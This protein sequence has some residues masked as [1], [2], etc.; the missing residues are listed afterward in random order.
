MK[1][2]KLFVLAIFLLTMNL[3]FSND[4]GK[5]DNKGFI[6]DWLIRGPYPNYQTPEYELSG[7]KGYV[8]DFLTGIGGETNA[9]FQEETPEKV[10]FV[11]D[12]SKLIA[13][14]GSTNEWGSRQTEAVMV[15][16]KQLHL[17]QGKNKVMFDGTFGKHDDYIVAYAACVLYSPVARSIKIRVGS[18]D[19]NKVWLNG[20]LVGS[21]NSSQGV[22]EDNF[23][24][25]AKLKKGLNRL[26]IK[27]VD[28]TGGFGF[29][30]ALSDV[31]NLPL[32]DIKVYL[33]SPADDIMKE[34]PQL[35]EILNWDNGCF[36]ASV[37]PVQLWTGLNNLELAVG[38]P[39]S[40]EYT[41]N[42][43]LWQKGNVL[44]AN[45]GSLAEKLNT[46][47]LAWKIEESGPAVLK[48]TLFNKQGEKVKSLES[49]CSI[50]DK[51][52]V[53]AENDLLRK[54]IAQIPEK[55]KKIEEGKQKDTQKLS[56]LRNDNRTLI[57]KI[58]KAYEQVHLKNARLFGDKGMS[59]DEP[60]SLNAP[61]RRIICLNGDQWKLS[62]ANK[63]DN[64]KIV[65]FPLKHK[66]QI[67][68]SMPF[69]GY[70]DYFRTWFLPIHKVIDDNGNKKI[71][72][73]PGWEDYKY[74]NLLSSRR[75]WLEKTISIDFYPSVYSVQFCA[76]NIC[77]HAVIYVNGKYEGEYRGMVGLVNI[78]VKNLHKGENQVVIYY[79]EPKTAGIPKLHELNW[80]IKGD[81]SLLFTSSI[82]TDFSNIKTSWRKNTVKVQTIIKNTTTSSEKVRAK[83]YVIKNGRIK[84]HISDEQLTIVAN[85]EK[86][87]DISAPWTDPQLWGI[88]DRC[89]SPVLYQFVTDLYIGDKLI[90]RHTTDFGFRE[91]WSAGTNIF[92]NGKR[93]FL[94]GDVGVGT[95][96]D[97]RKYMNVMFP[98]L[99]AEGIN[100]IRNHDSSYW[101]PV[102]FETCDRLGMYA[103]ANMYPVL[104][105]N[106]HSN[107]Q[108]FIPYDKWFEHP[109][110]K[111]NL[112]NY[113]SW[114][115]LI[116]NHPS[117]LV[118]STDNEIYT[119][120]WDKASQKKFNERNDKLGAW[121]GRYARS[122]EPE[123]IYTRNGDIGTWGWENKWHE[124]PPC[125]TANYHYPDFDLQK[126]TVNWQTK[127]KF[128]PLIYGE[129]LYCAYFVS[130][131][132]MPPT[133]ARVSKRANKLKKII[134]VY[135]R[136]EI[137]GQMYMG[138]SSDGFVKYDETGKGNPFG[139]KASQIE[140]GNVTQIKGFPKGR[141]TWPANSGPGVKRICSDI[142]C[143]KYG[144]EA[145]NWFNSRFP[146]HIRTEVNDAYRDCLLPMPELKKYPGAE[147]VIYLKSKKSNIA[148]T[149]E[150][151]E[152]MPGMVLT[153]ITD[154]NGNAYFELPEPGKYIFSAFGNKKELIV[155][156]MA[157][158][159]SQP[160]FDNIPIFI[161]N[162][163]GD[164]K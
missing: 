156:G 128:R 114:L 100:T 56:K 14:I 103:Y 104:H 4:Y 150:S 27:I 157:K 136:W 85:T 75:I 30:V 51:K 138:L 76:D 43:K 52:K 66:K 149:V 44:Q 6:T 18:D 36:L 61:Q 79:E 122:L 65:D 32:K 131:K 2:S 49:L 93:I 129:T 71:E 98:L 153:S 92:L 140:S 48:I 37:S 59:I 46:L 34:Y 152:Y 39:D 95:N 33:K 101:S 117:V 82:Y 142:S 108:H 24:Y 89:G 96:L 23:I 40:S 99:R 151:S 125:Q 163:A 5:L 26:L 90:D 41:Y 119:Q 159:A 102:F 28:R 106:E 144:T 113:K 145:T 17:Q 38:I 1:A 64:P 158:Y 137:P 133:P 77:G 50:F 112:E 87:F 67:N 73:L 120:A 110:H 29:C 155:P 15:S 35:K 19:D 115:K 127:F 88:G 7:G 135:R 116:A 53:E 70:S 130:P 54:Q 143:N 118:L 86:T 63:V 42:A 31:D 62:A 78:Q 69:I 68:I 83:Q 13:G 11:A 58:E 16:W 84:K 8:T 109:Y 12:F 111:I 20:K 154:A 124:D 97:T 139:I 72:S 80:G 74:D 164:E 146:S 9:K 141:V 55:I 132:W 126:T 121:Y 10:D 160:G 162:D 107:M 148:I 3:A 60:Y 22:K 123:Y 57:D 25:P 161:F 94:Q 147:C 91:V 45:E 47:K 21:A 134:P 105:E 81:V